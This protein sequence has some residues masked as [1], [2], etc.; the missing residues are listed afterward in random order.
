MSWS[1][2]TA[3]KYGVFHCV[4]NTM[5]AF[6]TAV[7]MSLWTHFP[8]RQI[9]DDEFRLPDLPN[10]Y[11]H[12][13]QLSDVS[14]AANGSDL[15]SVFFR[16]QI[17]FWK[18][19]EVMLVNTV[20]EVEEKALEQLRI[21]LKRVLAIGPVIPSPS[22]PSS[23]NPLSCIN[24]LNQHPPNSV[25]YVSFGS[26]N[27]IHPSQM[28]ELAEGLEA[29]EK[30]FIW[31][32]KPP[33][34]FDLKDHEFSPKWLPEG[35]ED[36]M[37]ERKRGL[38]VKTWAPQMEIL[39]HGSTGAFLSHCGWNSMLESL[40]WG[41]PIIG[42]PLSSEQFFNSKLVEEELGAGVEVAR[43]SK[44][45]EIGGV[46]V[47]RIIGLVMDGESEKG[48]E[49]RKRAKELMEMMKA[50]TEEGESCKGSSM[51]AMEEFFEAVACCRENGRFQ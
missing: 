9:Q 18:E 16:K 51:I 20:E 24:W 23:W 10:V 33:I 39:S 27:S 15:W 31:V 43:G 13:S 47:A 48:R 41:V 17:S 19:T 38:L 42:W 21:K 7:F 34:G 36:R 29:S 26:Q 5:G 4:F 40:S 14:R 11:L 6:G 25:L 30:P 3:K 8:H 45:A 28:M 32:I 50:A 46:D 1:V 44:A 22:P 2:E 49:V 12:R 35:F 37:T